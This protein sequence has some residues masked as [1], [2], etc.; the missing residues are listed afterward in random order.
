MKKFY[1]LNYVIRARPGEQMIPT[2]NSKDQL[3]N[4]NN[5]NDNITSISSSSSS[6]SSSNSNILNKQDKKRK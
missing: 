2:T 1:N 4:S 5:N 3:F 6:S